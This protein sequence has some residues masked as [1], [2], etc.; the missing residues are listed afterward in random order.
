MVALALTLT[1][2]AA[3]HA[4]EAQ[5]GGARPCL[6]AI[7]VNCGQPYQAL[8]LLHSAQDQLLSDSMSTFSCLLVFRRLFSSTNLDAAVM[9]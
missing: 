4:V 5:L 2:Y 8:K 7:A 9:Q 6:L 3:L 1:I